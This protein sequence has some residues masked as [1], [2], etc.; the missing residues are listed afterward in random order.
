[1]QKIAEGVLGAT[2]VWKE[3]L[4]RIPGLTAAVKTDLDSIRNKGMLET[5]KGIL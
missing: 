3:D 4:N 5:V 2:S 1:M